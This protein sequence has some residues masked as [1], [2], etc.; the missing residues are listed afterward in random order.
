IFCLIMLPGHAAQAANWPSKPVRILVSFPPGGSS[1][2]VARLLSKHL[3]DKFGQ[4][5]VVENKPGAGGTVAATALKREK[6]DGHTFMLS[7]LAPYS[8]APT[9]FRKIPYDALKD[10]THVSYIGTVYLGLFVSPKLGVKTLKDFVA[11]AKAEPGKL[12][13]GSSG[14][15]SWSNV[16]GF[17]F[18]KLANIDVVSIPYKGSRPMRQDFRGGVIPIMF[19]ALPQNIPAIKEGSAI[20]LAISAPA[21]TKAN[22]DLPTFKENGFD[23][24]AENWLGLTAP[25][26]LDASI[27]SRMDAAVAEIVA[28]PEIQ[29]KFSFWGLVH[30]RKTTKEFQSYVADQI[31]KWKPLI[32]ASGAKK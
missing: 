21:R 23:I 26:G 29:E 3:T 28:K 31:E 12:D 2:L 27:A 8:I 4:Q 16:I 24:V 6:G 7:N 11:K 18:N 15:G 10:F 1:D 19:D 30:T 20:A 25:A 22:P 14:V 5:F 17:Q 9:L 13:F 32:I